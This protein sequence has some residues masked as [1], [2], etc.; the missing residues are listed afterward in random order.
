MLVINFTAELKPA[1]VEPET[2]EPFAVEVVNTATSIEEQT[3]WK[4]PSCYMICQE[5]EV[6][7]KVTQFSY[8]LDNELFV[9]YFQARTGIIISQ[10]DCGWESTKQEYAPNNK[11]FLGHQIITKA[12]LQDCWELFCKERNLKLVEFVHPKSAHIK[13]MVSM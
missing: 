7:E 5:P 3:G 10:C 13:Y 2:T 8:D 4:R 12:R 6:L 9:G 1:A 11:V